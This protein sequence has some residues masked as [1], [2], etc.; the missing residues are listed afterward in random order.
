MLKLMLYP[1]RDSYGYQE[2]SQ[3]ISTETQN[4]LPRQRLGAVGNYFSLSL[5]FRCDMAKKQYLDAFLNATQAQSFLVPLWL[6]EMQLKF[7]ECRR[8][9][10][11]KVSHQAFGVF[12]YSFEIVAKATTRDIG[13]DGAIAEI[14]ANTDNPSYYLNL[15]EKLVNQDL[16]NAMRG[17]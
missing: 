9:G 12:D 8:I 17:V 2:Q 1:N 5:N 4:G 10:G 6:D 13:A 3:V 16:P 11:Y 15:L 7:Y 14:W